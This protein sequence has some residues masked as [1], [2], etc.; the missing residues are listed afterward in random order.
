[1]SS[2]PSRNVALAGRF[3][4][5]YNNKYFA[6]VNFG[7]NGSERFDPKYRWG[8]FPSIGAGW[9]VSDEA[10]WSGMKNIVPSLKIR[11][12]Y[13]LVGNDVIVTDRDRF[14]FTPNKIGRGSWRG[15]CEVMVWE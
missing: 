9:Q 1:D 5:G 6:E 11:A 8:F 14:F 3:T 4:Y 2:L 10:F 15:G 7:L 13:G 12:T